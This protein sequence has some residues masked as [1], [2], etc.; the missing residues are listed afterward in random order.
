MHKGMFGLSLDDDSRRLMV[1]SSEQGK[2]I[3]LY[4]A[5]PKRPASWL[6]MIS[7]ATA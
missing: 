6:R 4:R 1:I 2:E 5:G 7:H 3:G